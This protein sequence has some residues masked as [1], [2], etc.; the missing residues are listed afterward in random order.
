[1]WTFVS[2]MRMP[3]ISSMPVAVT[4]IGPTKYS[5]MFWTVLWNESEPAAW[6]KSFGWCLLLVKLACEQRILSAH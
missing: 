2:G 4:T 5:L 1:M 3:V 6:R